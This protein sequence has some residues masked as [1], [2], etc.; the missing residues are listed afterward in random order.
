LLVLFGP[1][2]LFIP[3]LLFLSCSS[4]HGQIYR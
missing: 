1:A 3:I 2:L 4:N